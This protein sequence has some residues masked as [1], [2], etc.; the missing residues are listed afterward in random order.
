MFEA[1]VFICLW[2]HQNWNGCDDLR[3]TLGPYK[4]LNECLEVVEKTKLDIKEN[5]DSARYV[6][7]TCL[8]PRAE[9]KQIK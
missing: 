8:P 7:Y 4:T 2:G 9:K 3:D 5:Y 6:G 1:V